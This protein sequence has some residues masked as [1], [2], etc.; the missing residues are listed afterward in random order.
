LPSG[1][2]TCKSI[3]IPDACSLLFAAQVEINGKN[4]F[5]WLLERYDVRICPEV[6][7]ECA[8]TIRRGGVELY[9]SQKFNN[10]VAKKL[11]NNIDYSRC[12]EYL[13]SYC[14]QQKDTSGFLSL[15]DGER[16]SLALGL[17]LNAREAKPVIILT[18]DFGAIKIF[19]RIVA[20]Q[21]FAIQMSIP[22]VI[23]SL[24]KTDTS[25]AQNVIQGALQ[26]YYHIRKNEALLHEV[27]RKRMHFACR[28][29]W[30][31]TCG[32]NCIEYGLPS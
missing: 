4:I 26:S 29:F 30:L 31:Q 3:C 13:D 12:L 22:D 2:I 10:Q 1:A 16:N 25:L 23:I 14:E 21:K 27:F 8:A 7:Y 32:A 15:G 11:V 5:E 6:K 28:D 24:F 18:D 17:F 9:N 19:D 20:E